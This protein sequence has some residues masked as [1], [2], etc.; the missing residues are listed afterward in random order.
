M[1]KISQITFSWKEIEKKK[2][3]DRLKLV[4]ENIPDEELML[5]LERERKKGRNDYPIRF[6]W[7]SIIAGIIFQHQSINSMIRELSRNPFLRELCGLEPLSKMPK[8]YIYTR[9]LK[10]LYKHNN[11]IEKIFNQL[12]L[13][14]QKELPDFGKHISGDGKAIQSLASKNKNNYRL[15]PDGRRDTE[16]DMG[17]KKYCGVDKHGQYYESF[18][19]WFGYKAHIIADSKYELPIAYEVTKASNSESK[20]MKKLLEKLKILNPEII[21][22]SEYCCLDKGYDNEALIKQ[23]WDDYRIKPIIDIRNMWK[24]KDKTRVLP[25]SK[26]IVYDYRGNISCYCPVNADMRDMAYAGFEKDRNTLKYRCPDQAYGIS[27]K[28]QNKCKFK[29]GLRI[30]LD[31]HRRLFTPLP[32]SSYKWKKIYNSRTSIERVNSRLDEFFGFEKHYNRG[33]KKIK[34]RLELSFITMLSMA[35]GRINQKQIEKLRSMTLAA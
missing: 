33:L 19:N 34:L 14:I 21:D 28:G 13:K 6:L 31:I 11:L 30:N 26:N 1:A 16:A 10:K 27:C 24:D 2:D 7:N 20:E 23:L 32:R 15:K 3:L 12:V 25:G 9:F 22:R 8:S 29:K 4:I 35:L 17:V 18:K 5:I